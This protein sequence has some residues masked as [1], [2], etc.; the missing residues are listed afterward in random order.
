MHAIVCVHTNLCFSCEFFRIFLA[1]YCVYIRLLTFDQIN[2]QL[3]NILELEI[4]ITRMHSA[5]MKPQKTLS[6]QSTLE[7]RK[8]LCAGRLH[9]NPIGSYHSYSIFDSQIQR[10][11]NLVWFVLVWSSRLVWQRD[12]ENYSIYCAH[13]TF[14]YY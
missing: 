7:K 1:M 12:M 9:A 2:E 13:K 5:L 6:I 4:C 11:Y 14:G 10:Y 8:S 3:T